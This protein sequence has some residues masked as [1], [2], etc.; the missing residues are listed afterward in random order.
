MIKNGIEIVKRNGI[1][2]LHMNGRKIKHKPW[3]GDLFSFLYDS[4]MSKSIFPK[5]LDAS[6]EKHT[7]FLKNEFSS[8]HNS[9]VLELATGSG[10]LSEILPCDNSYTGIDI[11]EGLLRIAYKKFTKAGFKNPELF[12]CSAEELP[13]QD[14]LYDI[15]ICNISLNFF[16][17]LD[18]VIKEVKRVLKNQGIFIC[19]VPVP[20]RNKKQSV[21]RGELYPENELKK[22]FE[23][24]GFRFTSYDF[25]NGALLYFK[26]ISKD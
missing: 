2:Y 14:M 19:S 25:R 24:K 9:N 18:S 26:V 7:L 11:S 20:E 6:I 12:V 22:L 13:F 4:I 5:K 23:M 10:N 15:C 8:V 17:D 16:S 21:I 3:L 1:N